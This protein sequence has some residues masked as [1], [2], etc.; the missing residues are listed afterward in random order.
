MKALGSNLRVTVL[1]AKGVGKSAITVRYLTK[2]F[3]GEYSSGLEGYPQGHPIPSFG[4]V[5]IRDLATR[6][7]DACHR[8][9]KKRL[10]RGLGEGL[11]TWSALYPLQVSSAKM[12]GSWLEYGHYCDGSFASLFC[13]RPEA[14]V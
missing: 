12:A 14:A 13:D 5:K 3:I 4:L 11:M 2:R 7:V 9:M 10:G 6:G 1:G 8:W